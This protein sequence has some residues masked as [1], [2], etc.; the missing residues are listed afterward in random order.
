MPER[1]LP[2]RRSGS[3]RSNRQA[4]TL[5][6]GPARSRLPSAK[7]ACGQLRQFLRLHPRPIVLHA[8]HKGGVELIEHHGHVA[9]GPVVADGVVHQVANGLFG[10]GGVGAD[11]G[12]GRRDGHVEVH[13]A[14]AGEWLMAGHNT[15]DQRAEV[16]RPGFNRHRAVQTAG[17]RQVRGTAIPLSHSVT[18]HVAADTP[19]LDQ[20]GS[21]FTPSS[22]RRTVHV[23]SFIFTRCAAICP[24]LVS[25]LKKVHAAIADAPVT[26]V[27]YSVD[28]TNDSVS[29]LGEFGLTR[30]IDPARWKLLT[31]S[32][33][34]VH[35]VAR[36]LYFADDDGMRKSLADPETFL[37]TEKVLLI[38][39]DG[40]I[41]G[42]YNG[43]Q[44]FEIQKLIEDLGVLNAA[45]Q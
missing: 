21:V 39:H 29:V 18:T 24:P 13:R 5:P 3:L 31:G 34:G 40:H 4:E 44:P 17:R 43:T 8:E 41:R 42:L 12:G 37:H 27:S 7:P 10:E 2:V 33:S 1:Q 38:D 26:L 22:L 9:A 6:V 16:D 28:P 23:V 19:F 11:D 36:D 25:S 20:T 14:G 45:E 15:F 30:G 35:Q 32:V